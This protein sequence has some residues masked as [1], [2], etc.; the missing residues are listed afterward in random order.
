MSLDSVGWFPVKLRPLIQKF[1]GPVGNM[2]A[3]FKDVNPVFSL[4]LSDDKQR[5]Y[6]SVGP[7]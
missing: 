4:L 2:E 5:E 3:R 7:N 1:Y 6:L